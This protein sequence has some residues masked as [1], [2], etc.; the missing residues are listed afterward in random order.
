LNKPQLLNRAKRESAIALP[1]FRSGLSFVFVTLRDFLLVS[2]IATAESVQ[3]LV[4][5]LS[6]GARLIA[7]GSVS[8]LFASSELN[9]S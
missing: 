8:P 9:G 6:L 1:S 2:N 5:A 3:C 7:L 4:G